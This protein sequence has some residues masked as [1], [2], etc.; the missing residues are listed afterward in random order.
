MILER[1]LSGLEY[2]EPLQEHITEQKKHSL[3]TQ[4]NIKV[5]TM[6]IVHCRNELIQNSHFTSLPSYLWK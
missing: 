1:L 3:N 6:V 5:D 4:P 2:C